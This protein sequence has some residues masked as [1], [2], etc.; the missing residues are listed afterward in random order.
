MPA[1]VRPRKASSE[2]SRSLEGGSM[3]NYSTANTACNN[4][5]CGRPQSPL[6][7]ASPPPSPTVPHDLPPPLPL[8]LQAGAQ[9]L[10]LLRRP[11]PVEGEELVPPGKAHDIAAHDQHLR[12]VLQKRAPFHVNFLRGQ[13]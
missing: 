7:P 5:K 12:R 1:M 2:S 9:F 8:L 11:R 3:E 6:T 10:K 4:M 13:G